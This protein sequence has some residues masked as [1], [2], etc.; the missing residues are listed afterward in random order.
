MLGHTGDVGEC[1]YTNM[2][3]SIVAVSMGLGQ[4]ALLVKVRLSMSPG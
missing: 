2:L 3:T 4:K 1:L